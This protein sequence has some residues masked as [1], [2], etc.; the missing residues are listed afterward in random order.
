MKRLAQLIDEFWIWTE[1]PKEKYGRT[2]M[3]KLPIYPELFP[4]IGEICDVCIEMINAPLTEE[5]IDLFLMGMAIDSED[6]DVL[7]NCL[8][9]GNSM[10]L[11]KL[12]SLGIK[13]PQSNA[14]WQLAELL[15]RDI[16][17]QRHFLSVLH[18]DMDEYVRKR[19]YNVIYDIQSM[20]KSE[21]T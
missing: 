9:K 6:E 3:N 15:R 17:D 10:F 11:H 5:E 18:N 21:T 1:L 16:P 19:A 14:R 7:E 4:K 8:N 12:V 2:D 20:E 13:H